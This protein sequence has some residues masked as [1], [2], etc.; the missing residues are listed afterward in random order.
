MSLANTLARISKESLPEAIFREYEDIG[1]RM[2]ETAKIGLTTYTFVLPRE[3]QV[4]LNGLY[5]KLIEDEFE[6]TQNVRDE[7]TA[8]IISWGGK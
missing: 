5:E 2:R 1:H 7:G 6:V 8:L 4:Y 3:K